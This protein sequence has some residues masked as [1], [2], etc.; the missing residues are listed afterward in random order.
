MS[1]DR[2]YI[3]CH[4]QENS[5]LVGIEDVGAGVREIVATHFARPPVSFHQWKQIQ[6][7]RARGVD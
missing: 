4:W 7:C 2:A 5:V 6:G 3:F 1:M